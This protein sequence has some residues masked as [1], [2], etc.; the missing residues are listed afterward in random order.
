MR[1]LRNNPGVVPHFEQPPY[2]LSAIV[3]IVKRTFVDIHTDKLI[4]KLTI[5]IA[6][7]LHRVA[8]RL[9]TM[10]NGVL[11]ALAQ[12]L[13]DAGHRFPPERAPDGISAE[14][15]RQSRNFLPPPA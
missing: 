6:G 9:F 2:S 4:G 3:A 10:I 8:E 1:R 7:K 15:Q 11:D 13:S 12:R 14:R 5:E